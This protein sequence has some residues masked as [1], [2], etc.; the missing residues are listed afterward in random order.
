MVIL[1]VTQYFWPENFR[2]NDL[3]LGLK[4]RGHEVIVFTGKPNYPSGKFFDGYGFFK[5]RAETW[6]GIRVI[7]APLVPRGKSSGSRL[8]INFISFA[9]FSA[10]RALL[11]KVNPDVIF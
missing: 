10:W 4:D 6:N 8:F 11:L 7:R 9:L 2:I 3:V 1:V 5:N